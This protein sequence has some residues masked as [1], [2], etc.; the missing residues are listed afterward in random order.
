ML[1]PF[2]FPWKQMRSCG[3]CFPSKKAGYFD[4]QIDPMSRLSGSLGQ[5]RFWLVMIFLFSAAGITRSQIPNIRINNPANTD[6]EEVTIAINPVNPL[7]LIAGA[8][9]TYSYYST[10]GGYSW[11]QQ[12]ITSAAY[13]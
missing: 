5:T 8:N 12:N 9:I 3:R 1:S 2:Y 10:D 4:M 6:P 13:G 7:N 11:H